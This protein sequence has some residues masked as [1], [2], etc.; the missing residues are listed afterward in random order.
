MKKWKVAH[1]Y[2][3]CCHTGIRMSLHWSKLEACIWRMHNEILRALDWPKSASKVVLLASLICVRKTC[4]GIT[5]SKKGP[6]TNQKYAEVRDGKDKIEL[7]KN[8]HVD[9]HVRCYAM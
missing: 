1:L 3:R 6:T 5:R 4:L 8:K 7:N 9:W 2:D